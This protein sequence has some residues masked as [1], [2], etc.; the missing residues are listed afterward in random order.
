M[1]TTP[2]KTGAATPVENDRF[3]KKKVNTR[4]SPVIN[5]QIGLIAALVLAFLIIELTSASTTTKVSLKKAKTYILE[6][7]QN[8]PNKYLIVANQPKKVKTAT[9]QQKVEII[10]DELPDPIEDPKPEPDPQPV[11]P[12]TTHNDTDTKII[13]DGK[14]SDKP[15]VT[16]N[17]PTTTTMLG[18]HEMPLFPGCKERYDNDERKECFNSRIHRFVNRRFNTGLANELGLE[19][20]SKIKIQIA[21]TI[22][23][24]GV[25]KDIKVRAPHP[26]LKKEALR[27]INKLP[28]IV[29][30]KVNGEEV[31]LKFALPIV[32]SIRN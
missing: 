14:P 26:E 6:P 9:V 30:G 29:P 15:V 19:P 22:D 7:E 18:L 13:P 24:N 25:V 12:S 20:G 3:D 1:K 28:V 2:Q 17:T 8:D 31:N 16:S 10:P 32:F 27:V 4:V 23:T 5:F 21:F 11:E